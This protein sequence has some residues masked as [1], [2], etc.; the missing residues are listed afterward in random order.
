MPNCKVNSKTKKKLLENANNS[1]RMPPPHPIPNNLR[2]KYNKIHPSRN[3]IHAVHSNIHSNN[4]RFNQ[5]NH[6]LITNLIEYLFSIG[7]LYHSN[8]HALSEIQNWKGNRKP[9]RAKR[10]QQVY[11]SIRH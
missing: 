3:T 2:Q 1:R 8:L 4:A 11:A 6:K 7:K 10:V 9:N 5:Y